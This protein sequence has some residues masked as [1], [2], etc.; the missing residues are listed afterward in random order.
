VKKLRKILNKNEFWMA[1][2]ALATT[3]W[4]FNV[5]VL[6]S[7]IMIIPLLIAVTRP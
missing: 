1:V 2:F 5:G 3:W 4:L 7:L 6:S